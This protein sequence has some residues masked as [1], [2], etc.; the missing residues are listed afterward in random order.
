MSSGNVATNRKAYHEYFLLEKFEAGMELIG[1]EV[2]SLRE[3]HANLKEGYITLRNGEAWAI[4]L[5]INP[6]SHTGYSGHEPTRD[7]RLLLN[8][9]EIGKLQRA[10]EQKGMTI[11]PLRIYFKDG[12]AKLEIAVAKGK[13]SYDKKEAIK[14]KDIKRQSEREMGNY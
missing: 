1:S 12:W 7:R 9:R 2:K 5:H 10:V 8:R 4:G 6:Y 3:G 14:A 13:K 11:V